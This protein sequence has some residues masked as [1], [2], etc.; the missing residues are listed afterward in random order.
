LIGS[1]ATFIQVNRNASRAQSTAPVKN[2]RGG[3][4]PQARSCP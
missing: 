1:L 4:G 3:T 2:L